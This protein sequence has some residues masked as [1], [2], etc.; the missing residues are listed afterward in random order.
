AICAELIARL[1]TDE[2]KR[3]W[4]PGLA[5]GTKMVFAV[6]EPDAG[7]NTHNVATTATRDGDVYRVRGTKTFISGIDEAPQVLVVVRTG[8]EEGTGRARL[9]LLVVDSDAPGL[10]RSPVPVEIASPEKQFMLFFDNVE[11]PVDRLVGD[12]G[13]GLRQVFFGLNPERITSACIS[14]GIGRYALGK[15]SGYA[16]DRNV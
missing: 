5:A 15:A 4:L 10:N 14:N 6:T 8:T 11:V 2:Q 7:S 13:D 1:G 9:S 12:E 16:H 3:R